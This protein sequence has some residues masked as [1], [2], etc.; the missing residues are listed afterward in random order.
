MANQEEFRH[1]CERLSEVLRREGVEVAPYREPEL[2][3]YSKLTPENQER[4]LRALR[5]YLDV[6]LSLHKDNLSMRDTASFCW[7]A[8]D[9]WVLS[10]ASDFFYS[11][12]PDDSVEIY[13]DDGFQIFRNLRFFELSSYSVEELYSVEWWKLFLRD[14]KVTQRLYSFFLDILQ[15]RVPGV[16]QLD[17]GEHQVQ[18]GCSEGKRSFLLHP[19]LG[20]ALHREGLIR[21]VIVSQAVR[22]I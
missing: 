5:D 4:A 17:I 22:R 19:H 2:P 9:R 13:T 12:R 18:E 16:M 6:C 15:G 21:G 8:L 11:L 7:R 14:E 3:H 1:L 20:S 10:G